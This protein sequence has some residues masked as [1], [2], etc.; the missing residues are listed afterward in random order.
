MSPFI[1]E[2]EHII[3]T[4]LKC[5]GSTFHKKA[6]ILFDHNFEGTKTELSENFDET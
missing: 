1:K 4:P 5:E 6:L 2:E 3:K